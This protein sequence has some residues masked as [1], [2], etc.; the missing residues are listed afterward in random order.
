V[1]KEGG[2]RASDVPHFQNFAD[3]IRAGA[4]LNSPISEGRKSTMLC[5]HGNIAFRTGTA[6]E[7]DPKTGRILK[8]PAAQKLWQREYRQGWEPKV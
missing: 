2:G 6:L 4:K 1:A 5:H 7:V 3:A 8:N